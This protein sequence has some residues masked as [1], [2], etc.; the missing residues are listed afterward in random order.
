MT[1]CSP[2]NAAERTAQA[3]KQRNAERLRLQS[4]RDPPPEFPYPLPCPLLCPCP[5][6]SSLSAQAMVAAFGRVL[7]A[8]VLDRGGIGFV[9]F[10]DANHAEDAVGARRSA[11][12]EGLAR[13]QLDFARVLGSGLPAG[14]LILLCFIIQRGCSG[15]RFLFCAQLGSCP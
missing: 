7:D 14:P 3:A 10:Q 1:Q 4:S 6:T 12:E 11:D 2:K 9:T 5:S 15:V 13:S 8:K